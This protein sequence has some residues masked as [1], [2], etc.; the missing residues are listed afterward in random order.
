MNQKKITPQEN[1]SYYN[2]NSNIRTLFVSAS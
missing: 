2:S 1:N